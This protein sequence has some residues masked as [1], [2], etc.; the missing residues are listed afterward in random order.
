MQASTAQSL[1][2]DSVV[3]HK[4]ATRQVAAALFLISMSVLLLE[5]VLTRIFSALMWYHFAFLAV[6]LAMGGM[7]VGGAL[8]TLFPGY[9]G[10]SSGAGNSSNAGSASPRGHEVTL[11]DSLLAPGDA[12][13][14]HT[15]PGRDRLPLTAMHNSTVCVQGCPNNE[16]ALGRAAESATLFGLSTVIALCLLTRLTIIPY[17][18]TAGL[19]S[20]IPALFLFAVPFVHAGVSGALLLTAFRSKAG[21]LYAFD[22]FG[23]ATGCLL[24]VA[25][26]GVIDPPSCILIA[27]AAAILA[28]ILLQGPAKERRI[29]GVVFFV[30][31][32]IATIGQLMTGQAG[33]PAIGFSSFKGERNADRQVLYLKW[34][35]CSLLRV[36]PGPQK[37]FYWGRS[38]N[39]PQPRIRQF[40]LDIDATAA[41]FIT[42]YGGTRPSDEQPG[43]SVHISST[44]HHD[45]TA[46]ESS[47][48]KHDTAREPSNSN[49]TVD[50]TYL[51]HDI[52]NFAHYLRPDSHV[53]VIGVGGGRDILS[54]LAFEQQHVTGIEFND[55]ILHL[56]NQRYGDFTGHLDKNPRVTL[57]NSEA[58]NYIRHSRT[59]WDI[60][61]ASL[62]DTWAASTAGAYT[63]SEN[64]LYTTDAWHEFRTHLSPRGLLS[65][66]RWYS[67]DSTPYEFYRLVSLAAETLRQDGICDPSRYILA[68]YSPNPIP[69][70]PHMST[71]TVL[72]SRSPFDD[73]DLALARHHAR[74]SGYRFVVT[75]DGCEN[76]TLTN[77]TARRMQLPVE[78]SCDLSAPTD[79]RPYFFQ[80]NKP[81]TWI[82]K[83][84]FGKAS[85]DS[86]VTLVF[87]CAAS[88]A[89]LVTATA[90]SALPR[91]WLRKQSQSENI[92]SP[93]ES[94]VYWKRDQTQTER[95]EAAAPLVASVLRSDSGTGVFRI[96][97]YFVLIGFA[98]MFAEMWAMQRLTLALGHSVFSLT[99]VLFSF[100]LGAGAGAYLGKNHS[101]DARL[102]TLISVLALFLVWI[103]ATV[104]DSGASIFHR[105]LL[106]CL[107]ILPAA[108]LA[109][110]FFP[111]GIRIAASSRL[112]HLIPWLWALNGA[113]SVAAS[114]ISVLLSIKFGISSVM[115]AAI[116]CYL[117]S[118]PAI[119]KMPRD[120]PSP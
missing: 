59:N 102:R 48:V 32:I 105:C 75:P 76:Q 36:M 43:K 51:K 26:L 88:L 40:Y 7:S 66:S 115:I 3:L 84:Q 45:T 95:P 14:E 23:A 110:T 64:T 73:S 33:H 82:S 103:S 69:E 47:L 50:I 101:I 100:L 74:E 106:A 58:R 8:I 109:G 46:R 111:F 99:V 72:V 57:I 96:S 107:L 68:L 9:Y 104:V 63:L 118:W 5:I 55:G 113:A 117:I 81:E 20:L 97:L 27:A 30:L 31:T 34:N 17:L 39:A 62:I 114:V 53:C 42:E 24:V 112:G 93:S 49:T 83:P 94:K 89:L 44:D 86:I 70:L 10:V 61:Q 67:L 25:L 87:T 16:I 79:D 98:F 91:S 2:K 15:A 29:S 35:A 41:S 4:D 92:P 18:T 37:P 56:L 6:S 77:L 65:F 1:T 120:L 11:P 108:A 19:L 85:F 80:M 60:I 28:G 21:Q 38:A 54:A 119:E 52:T 12:P 90:A 78:S 13:H 71:G 22:L 116:A